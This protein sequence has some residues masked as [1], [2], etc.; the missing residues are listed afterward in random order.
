MSSNAGAGCTKGKGPSRNYVCLDTFNLIGIGIQGICQL[1]TSPRN[2][3][4]DVVQTKHPVSVPLIRT[5][6]AVVGVHV[7]AYITYHYQHRPVWATSDDADR[8]VYGCL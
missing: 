7:I 1:S 2:A 8:Y 6:S 3:S 5:A 4:V